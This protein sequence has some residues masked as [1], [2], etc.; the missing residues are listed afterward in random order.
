MALKRA[1]EA[2]R[3]AVEAEKENAST[4]RA[5]RRIVANADALGQRGLAALKA[6]HD[7]TISKLLRFAQTTVH[8]TKETSAAEH[9]TD[10]LRH[11][12]VRLLECNEAWCV[13]GGG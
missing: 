13:Y 4:V 8:E 11:E 10:L 2:G 9:A 7:M 6:Q 5:L 12:Q 3:A 1:D